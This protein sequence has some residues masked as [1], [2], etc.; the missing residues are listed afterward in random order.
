MAI[1]LGIVPETKLLGIDEANGGYVIIKPNGDILCY[2]IYD[3]NRLRN[4]LYKN[5]KFDSPSSSR[6]GA[7]LLVNEEDGV[8]FRLT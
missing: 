6:T 4:Y 8:K 1:A 3:R 2:H 7:S 5:T